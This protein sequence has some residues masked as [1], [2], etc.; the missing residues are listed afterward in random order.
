MYIIK[1]EPSHVLVIKIFM[2]NEEPNIKNIKLDRRNCFTGAV[3]RYSDDTH[4]Q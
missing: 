4:C 3:D 1:E 2:Y